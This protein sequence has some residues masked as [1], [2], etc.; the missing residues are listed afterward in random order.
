MCHLLWLV[1]IALSFSS[2][3]TTLLPSYIYIS[4]RDIFN[5]LVAWVADGYQ[6]NIQHFK[7]LTTLTLTWRPS[8]SATAT[9]VGFAPPE[10]RTRTDMQSGTCL[11]SLVTFTSRS[12]C[13]ARHRGGRPSTLT[14]AQDR[15][16]VW[17]SRQSRSHPERTRREA[18]DETARKRVL[19]G[20]DPGPR[21]IDRLPP[22]STDHVELVRLK[23]GPKTDCTAATVRVCT[24]TQ[25]SMYMRASPWHL[26]TFE[27]AYGS[28]IT[29]GMHCHLS[30]GDIVD[31]TLSPCPRAQASESG[32]PGV[33]YS[34]TTTTTT[35]THNT[36]ISMTRTCRN[37]QSP[38]HRHRHRTTK[39]HE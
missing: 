33:L 16:S 35:T 10:T 39:P 25:V 21:M 12:R 32:G 19:E 26:H 18:L 15:S 27:R 34:Y 17:K 1:A 24:T 22:P 38:H 4:I 8:D 36:I 20:P 2:C 28:G 14:F 9:L 3:T 31:D 37:P 6:R 30:E 11:T 5:G 23:N 29:Y 13:Q 7:M